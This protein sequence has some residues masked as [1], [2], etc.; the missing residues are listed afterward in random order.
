MKQI[1]AWTNKK[2]QKRLEK[3]NQD[4]NMLI[5]FVDSYDEFI[6]HLNKD[7]ILLISM[8]KIYMNHNKLMNLVLENPKRLF[9]ILRDLNINLPPNRIDSFLGQINVITRYESDFYKLF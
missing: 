1:V 5:L 4:Y 6:K 2:I 9:F 3:L 7:E 8:R